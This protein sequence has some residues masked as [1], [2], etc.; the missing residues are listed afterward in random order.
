[1]GVD[2]LWFLTSSPHPALVVIF[3]QLYSILTHPRWPF[4]G[5]YGYRYARAREIEMT[6]AVPPNYYS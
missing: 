3:T 5:L 2:S 4:N 1:M 6:S